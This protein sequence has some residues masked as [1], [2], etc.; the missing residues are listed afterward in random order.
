MGQSALC[1]NDVILF[2]ARGSH[3]EVTAHKFDA[4]RESHPFCKTERIA[5]PSG[6]ELYAMNLTLICIRYHSR[7]PSKPRAHIKNKACLLNTRK[8]CQFFGELNSPNMILICYLSVTI[9]G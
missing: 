2:R 9:D 6:C 4:L 8:L 1:D 7:R 3:E 5:V